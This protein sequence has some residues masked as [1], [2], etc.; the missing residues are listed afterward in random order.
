[1]PKRKPVKR[2]RRIQVTL[3]QRDSEFAI[4]TDKDDIT[5]PAVIVFS[6]ARGSGKTYACIMLMKHFELKRYISRTFLLC[7]TRHSNDLYSNLKTLSPLDSFED[8]N[9]FNVA[10][11]FILNEVK[12][13]WDVYT[14]E[15]EYA[16]VFFKHTQGHY[17]TLQEQAMLERRDGMPPIKVPKPSHLL[18]VD[19][20]Q[21]TDLYSNARKDLLTHMVIKHR[22]I[23][24]T[25]ALL[26]Q[27]WT[28]IPRVIRLNTT[29]FAVYKTGDKT[30]LKQIYDTF[31]NTI[32]FEEFEKIYHEAIEEPHGFL[33]IDTVPKK[34]S[35]RFRSGF[36]HYLIPKRQHHV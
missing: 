26:A 16:K 13:D 11:H 6:G 20:A 1:M 29:Q 3:T 33:F 32:E 17:L 18:I 24:I 14:K 9:N 12:Q 10:L 27:S 22:H 19:D 21:G 35:Q 36:N 31:A 15:K 23:P 2:A 28:G 30:Q 25:I 4:K 5:L 8:E 34:E 7:P